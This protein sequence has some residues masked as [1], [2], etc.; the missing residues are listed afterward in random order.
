MPHSLPQSPT[1]EEIWTNIWASLID[2][3]GFSQH[4]FNKPILASA[5]D[6]G[7]EAR[8]IV[9]RKVDNKKKILIC[10]SDVRS[11]KTEQLRRSP[12]ASWLFWDAASR[13]QLRLTTASTIHHLDEVA[14]TAWAE[15]SPTSKTNY[16]VALRPGTVIASAEA[17]IAAYDRNMSPEIDTARTWF[18]HFSVIHSTVVKADW[19]CLSRAGHRRARFIV[20]DQGV[21]S[22]WIVP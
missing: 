17:G 2:G 11:K 20:S 14:E 16:S 18:Q 9:L 22:S 13:I 12:V 5:G 10:H 19:L 8:T 15:L 4:P 6:D 21:D 1:L 7:P 3:A